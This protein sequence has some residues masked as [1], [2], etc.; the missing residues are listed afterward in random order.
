[1]G[2]LV[3]LC[4][5]SSRVLEADAKPTHAVDATTDNVLLFK[6][7]VGKL[8]VCAQELEVPH[9]QD[10][11]DVQM[12]QDEGFSRARAVGDERPHT[13]CL[14]VE[15]VERAAHV[16]LSIPDHHFVADMERRADGRV[17]RLVRSGRCKLAEEN[18]PPEGIY[19][20]VLELVNLQLEVHDQQPPE[21]FST[22]A[23]G[24][25]HTTRV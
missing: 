18:V 10:Q 16:L 17:E 21:Q 13:A 1:M 7:L 23:F 2:D 9:V 6:P 3:V 19:L 25:D 12:R 24:H 22:F 20:I 4:S 15:L 14:C 11:K 5:S 8:L